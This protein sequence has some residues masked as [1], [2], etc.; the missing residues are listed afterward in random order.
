MNAL[1]HASVW[2]NPV[3]ANTAWSRDLILRKVERETGVPVAWIKGKRR[4]K[5]VV[6]A[7]H[8]AM[9]LLRAN[10]SM[11]LPQIGK[12]LGGRDHTTVIHGI[13]QH[14]RRAGLEVP[15]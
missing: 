1:P 6:H 14:C 9:Y 8:E 15:R 12:A 2:F 13:R 4:F 3:R 5:G 11:S 7:R 10:T